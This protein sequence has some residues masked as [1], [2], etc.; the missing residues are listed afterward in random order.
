M[1]ELIKNVKLNMK[2][3]TCPDGVALRSE[4]KINHEVQGKLVKSMALSSGKFPVT[5]IFVLRN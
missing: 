2:D 4:G 3:S 5:I 1:Q